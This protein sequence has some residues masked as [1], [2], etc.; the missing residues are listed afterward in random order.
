MHFCTTLNSTHVP[1]GCILAWSVLKRRGPLGVG[2]DLSVFPGGVVNVV[3]VLSPTIVNITGL[4]VLVCLVHIQTWNWVNHWILCQAAF[5]TSM[6]LQEAGEPEP[7]N[8]NQYS[9]SLSKKMEE[10]Q[11]AVSPWLGLIFGILMNGRMTSYSCIHH[12]W[13]TCGFNKSW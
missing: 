9:T 1:S 7:Y 2:G 3:G 6:V 12:Q 4:S 8:G 13:N 10:A 5:Y 11:T